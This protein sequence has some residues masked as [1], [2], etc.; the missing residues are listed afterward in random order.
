MFSWLVVALL[1]VA[2]PVLGENR[3][4]A[5]Q[6]K[7]RHEN[8]RAGLSFHKTP[9]KNEAASN[10]NATGMPSRLLMRNTCRGPRWRW[11]EKH[12]YPSVTF[13]AWVAQPSIHC[14]P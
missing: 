4:G 11:D 3:D 7:Q 10:R 14:L 8:E 12:A 9:P 5:R 13:Y 1:V 6:E 2:L